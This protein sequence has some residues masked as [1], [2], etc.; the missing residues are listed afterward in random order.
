MD[1]ASR[2]YG[3]RA[4]LTLC[5]HRDDTLDGAS[6][7]IVITEWNQFRSPDF[8]ELKSRLLEPVVFDGRN[9]FE[10]DTMDSLGFSHYSIGRPS[11][12]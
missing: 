11:V 7:L 12:S 5:D 6:G 3:N 2:I 1:E 9:L 10:P 4:D 8:E